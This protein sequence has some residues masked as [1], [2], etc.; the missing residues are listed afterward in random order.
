M[1]GRARLNEEVPLPYAAAASSSIFTGSAVNSTSSPLAICRCKRLCSPAARPFRNSMKLSRPP[2]AARPS[3]T[4][5]DM[6]A[7]DVKNFMN[8]PLLALSRP[9]KARTVS[10]ATHAIWPEVTHLAHLS[11]DRLAPHRFHCDVRN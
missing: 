11:S 10:Q 3:F 4:P 1:A 9:N 2:F 7:E 5:W 8:D 6:G